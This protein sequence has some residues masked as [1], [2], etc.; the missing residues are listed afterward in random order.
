[1]KIARFALPGGTIGF[2]PVDGEEVIDLSGRVPSWPA[3]V[4]DPDAARP[5]PRT[6]A[7]P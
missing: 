3:L 1:M 2:G 7:T 4:A 5:T 6:R